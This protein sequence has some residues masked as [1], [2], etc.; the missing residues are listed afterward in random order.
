MSDMI[1]FKTFC[2][3]QYRYVHFT[4]EY[5]TVALFIKYEV[6]SYIAN[7]YDV[8]RSQDTDYIVAAIDE[9]I[10]ERKAGNHGQ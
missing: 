8:L 2:I 9:Y 4:S 3:E 1:E 6:F 10:S 7:Y 5:D